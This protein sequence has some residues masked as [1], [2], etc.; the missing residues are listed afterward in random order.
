MLGQSCKLQN[1]RKKGKEEKKKTPLSL[2]FSL[3][4]KKT[5]KRGKR[6]AQQSN[7]LRQYGSASAASLTSLEI[8]CGIGETRP[9]NTNTLNVMI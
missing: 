2:S 7:L 5:R 9:P 3:K 8:A 4:K 1:F 6:A